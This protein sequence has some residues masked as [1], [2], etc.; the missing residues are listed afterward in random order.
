[1]STDS[2]HKPRE[3]SSRHSLGYHRPASEVARAYAIALQSVGRSDCIRVLG[4]IIFVGREA[5][6][7]SDIATMTQRVRAL[8]RSRGG[9]S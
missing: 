8:R 4:K 3:N 6:S 9:A 7:I 5:Y 1:M 2:S